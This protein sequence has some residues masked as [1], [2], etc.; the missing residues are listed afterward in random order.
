MKY[1][2]ERVTY[3]I[4]G[5]TFRIEAYVSKE[6]RLPIVTE[7]AIRIIRVVGDMPILALRQYLGLSEQETAMLIDELDRQKLA[8]VQEESIALTPYAVSHFESSSDELPRFTKI[9]KLDDRVDFE[10]LTFSPVNGREAPHQSGRTA[11]LELPDAE[12]LSQSNLKA[13]AAYQDQFERILR[14]KGASGRQRTDV[15]KVTLVEGDRNFYIPVTIAFGLDERGE[16]LRS[17]PS[18]GPEANPDSISKLDALISDKLLAYPRTDRRNLAEQFAERFEDRVIAQYAD[19]SGF[20]WVDYLKEVHGSGPSLYSKGTQPLFGSLYLGRNRNSLTDQIKS[21]IGSSPGLQATPSFWMAPDLSLW[22]RSSDA[23][24]TFDA[25]GRALGN[26]TSLHSIFPAQDAQYA[27]IQ[28]Q[29]LSPRTLYYRPNS[30]WGGRL[31]IVLIQPYLAVCVIHLPLSEAPGVSA[32]V[33]FVTTDPRRIEIARKTLLA[34]VSGSSYVPVAPP[35][36]RIHKTPLDEEIYKCLNYVP[37]I[38]TPQG[39][40]PLIN[41]AG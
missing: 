41:G 39:C 1:E 22:G 40:W 37:I 20:R 27:S 23:K 34:S 14:V 29:T 19:R 32:A 5:R 30:D 18:L 7:F 2:F 10:L 13:E 31:E 36:G 21:A 12:A 9:E 24:S 25:L 15:Y 3:S 16:Y 6:E 35:K 38:M 8:V 28:S 17:E 33:G 4:P 26:D 11:V